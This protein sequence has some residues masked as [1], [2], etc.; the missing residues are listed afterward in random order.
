MYC[1]VPGQLYGAPGGGI[2]GFTLN[3]EA[4]LYTKHWTLYNIGI[5]QGAANSSKTTS[6]HGKNLNVKNLLHIEN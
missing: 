4:L 6:S 5:L 3:K 1:T 2:R